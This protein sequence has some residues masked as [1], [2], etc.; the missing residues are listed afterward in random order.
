MEENVVNGTKFAQ[1]LS[2]FFKIYVW[3]PIIV[4]AAKLPITMVLAM[5]LATSVVNN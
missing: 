1:S 5:V 3:N 4:L 2:M